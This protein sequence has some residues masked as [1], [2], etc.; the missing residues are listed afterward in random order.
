MAPRHGYQKAVCPR[1]P[2]H[3]SCRILSAD[4]VVTTFGDEVVVVVVVKTTMPEAL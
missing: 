3:R 2:K 4:V 1:T